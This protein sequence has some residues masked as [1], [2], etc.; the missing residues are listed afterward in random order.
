VARTEKKLDDLK[1]LGSSG[2]WAR[3]L[4][5]L[6]CGHTTN[7]DVQRTLQQHHSKYLRNGT[8]LGWH[9]LL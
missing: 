1:T 7:Q 9:Q 2:S 5:Q 3:L 8:P 4:A 6:H